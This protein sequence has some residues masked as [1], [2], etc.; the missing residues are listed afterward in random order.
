MHYYSALF[1]V[2]YHYDYNSQCG[3]ARHNQHMPHMQL[4]S[5]RMQHIYNVYTP[6]KT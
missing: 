1:I 3:R 5:R 2:L 6:F 4:H